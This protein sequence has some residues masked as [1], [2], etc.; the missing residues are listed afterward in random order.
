MSDLTS[1]E[2]LSELEFTNSRSSGAGGQNVNKVNSKVTLR[3]NII[4]S[5]FLTDQQKNLLLLKLPNQLSNDGDLI[6]SSQEYRS[7]LQNKQEVIL[8][9][10]KILKSVFKKQKVRKASKP[11]KAAKKKRLEKKK[12]QSEKKQMRKKIL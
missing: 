12:I 4:N 6:L 9:L 2:L 7:Q 11:S 8:K 5:K 1:N 10:D 3:W